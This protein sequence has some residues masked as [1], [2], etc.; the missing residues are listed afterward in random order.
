[1]IPLIIL[2]TIPIFFGIVAVSP[3]DQPEEFN[4]ETILE[5]PEF[6]E[7]SSEPGVNVL[8][9]LLIVVWTIILLRIVLQIKKGTFKITKR[10]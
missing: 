10:Y 1:M 2:V 5:E 8:H 3:F 4:E 7:I 6:N 9:F